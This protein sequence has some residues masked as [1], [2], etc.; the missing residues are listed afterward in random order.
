MST[1]YGPTEEPA[2]SK[3][4]IRLAPHSGRSSAFYKTRVPDEDVLRAQEEWERSQGRPEPDVDSSESFKPTPWQIEQGYSE[5]GLRYGKD[6][7]GPPQVDLSGGD[8][9]IDPLTGAPF[10]EHQYPTRERVTDFIARVRSDLENG[11]DV[12]YLPY[13]HQPLPPRVHKMRQDDLENNEHFF[14]T[15]WRAFAEGPTGSLL[16]RSHRSPYHDYRQ[17]WHWMLSEY[18]ANFAK[19][20]EADP[21]FNVEDLLNIPVTQDLDAWSRQQGFP[22]S[23]QFMMSEL[24]PDVPREYWDT[25]LE[26]ES[27]DEFYFLRDH[28]GAIGYNQQQIARSGTGQAIAATLVANMAD[29]LYLGAF[30]ATGGAMATAG[31]TS[32]AAILAARTNTITPRIAGSVIGGLQAGVSVGLV[33]NGRRLWDPQYTADQ[34]NH[35][36]ATAFAF[37]SLMGWGMPKSMIGR[38]QSELDNLMKT[39]PQAWFKKMWPERDIRVRFDSRNRM[40]EVVVH[41]YADGPKGDI[42]IQTVWTRENGFVTTPRGGPVPPTELHRLKALPV[43]LKSTPTPRR[44]VGGMRTGH[45]MIPGDDFFPSGRIY[46]GS[47]AAR[48]LST[49]LRNTVNQQVAKNI[50]EDFVDDLE[51]DPDGRAIQELFQEDLNPEVWNSLP[52]D[53]KENIVDLRNQ[54]EVAWHEQLQD[55]WNRMEAVTEITAEN[56]LASAYSKVDGWLTEGRVLQA[57]RVGDHILVRRYVSKPTDK[58]TSPQEIEEVTLH[59]DAFEELKEKYPT[60]TKGNPIWIVE[61]EDIPSSPTLIDPED[62]VSSGVKGEDPYPLAEEPPAAPAPEAPTSKKPWQDDPEWKTLQEEKGKLNAELRGLGKIK[63]TPKGSPERT[64]LREQRKPLEDRLKE[65]RA[66]QKEIKEGTSAEAPAPAPVPA[67]PPTAPVDPPTAPVDPPPAPVDPLPAPRTDRNLDPGRRHIRLHKFMHDNPLMRELRTVAGFLFA[68]HNPMVRILGNLFMREGEGLN[69]ASVLAIES[70]MMKSERWYAA[71][72]ASARANKM[73]SLFGHVESISWKANSDK[74]GRQRLLGE[75]TEKNRKFNDDL[76]TLQNAML[77]EM[78]E[79]F[80]EISKI[81]RNP[82][83]LPHNWMHEK[84]A[85]VHRQMSPKDKSGNIDWAMGHQNFIKWFA[86]SFDPKAGWSTNAKESAA[87]FLLK[88]SEDSFFRGMVR[89]ARQGNR[90]QYTTLL[91]HARAHFRG[92][93]GD[94]EIQNFVSTVAEKRTGP[95]FLR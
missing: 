1:D 39:D 4:L 83:Y 27:K 92:S 69:T 93:L 43:P 9:R 41:R 95:G 44:G 55:N 58:G 29:P 49:F 87:E 89:E 67:D 23:L 30:A 79:I 74:L 53:I 82:N 36:T 77:D 32:R 24:A 20:F 52:D 71:L 86:N 16:T 61:T 5:F 91:K 68:Q 57:R 3:D 63:D 11:I 76:T 84:I 26:A 2:L 47:T 45:A 10:T 25:L 72:V 33:D 78:E 81:E 18:E 73:I 28:Y 46:S 60:D 35:A 48:T 19:D 37:G 80:P 51:N 75:V 7:M 64:A 6:N 70:A 88:I 12:P 90:D 85:A 14:T 94:D 38:A 59:Q 65:I 66:R 13:G 21:D 31:L 34:A 15:M 42:T 22:S 50:P 62:I 17:G 56:E 54:A 40:S 8:P